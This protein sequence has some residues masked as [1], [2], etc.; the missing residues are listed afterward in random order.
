MGKEFFALWGNEKSGGKVDANL[1][2][3]IEKKVGID[4]D[5]VLWNGFYTVNDLS[6]SD[7]LKEILSGC[8]SPDHVSFDSYDRVR[9][10]F[11]KGATDY[12]E[13]MENRRVRVVDA[14]VYPTEDEV[15]SLMKNLDRN[16][17]IVT[18]GG[19]TSVT[20]GVNPDGKS[21]FVISLDTGNLNFLKVDEINLILEVG[22]G[23]K[24]PEIE[25]ETQKFN[26]TLGNFPESFE[27]ST[28]GGWIGTN[29]AGQESN[30]YGRTKD[31]VIGLRIET[32]RGMFQDRIVPGESAFFKLSDIVVGNEGTFGVVTRA[33]LKL[34]KRPDELYYKAYM[35]K[36]FNDGIQSL[37]EKFENGGTPIISRLS[38]ERETELSLVGI[39][40]SFVNNLFKKYVSSR[41]YLNP[42]AILIAVS[43]RKDDIRFKNGLNLGSLPAKY[44]YRDRFSRPYIYNQL[45]KRG[46]V[47]DTIETSAIWDKLENIHK[48][49]DETF[50]EI[51]NS[52]GVNGII[53][54]HASH[55]Y[56][57][58]SALYFTFLFYA[59]NNRSHYLESIRNA[60]IKNII[61]NGG[62]ISHHHGIGKLHSPFLREYK[63]GSYDLISSVKDFFDPDNFLNPG[64]LENNLE[65][66][67]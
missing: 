66:M 22:A 46:I 36:S 29:A 45:L 14:V 65:R 58:G 21:K 48:A 55:Q 54:C 60:V 43:D 5:E 13:L 63:G 50:E 6:V 26:L 32:P 18:F 37:K 40:D 10:S 30:R 17:E 11:G 7:G 56:V 2:S 4:R 1:L 28:V 8:V 24:G 9:H 57:N 34:H 62:S 39:K 61:G 16:V 19:G 52:L 35:F 3:F 15:K 44:W 51:I 47:A 67:G 64:I 23:V 59:D 41:G 27:Y 53:L 38:D 12:I 33:W 42:S 49:T 25:Q 20:G 31:F